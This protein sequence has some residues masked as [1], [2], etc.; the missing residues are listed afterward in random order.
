MVSDIRITAR[1]AAVKMRRTTRAPRPRAARRDAFCADT[2]ARS[3]RHVMPVFMLQRY[4]A[5][6]MFAFSSAA[7]PCAMPLPRACLL[8]K[9][10]LLLLRHMPRVMQREYQ[11]CSHVAVYD[12]RFRDQTL[13]RR[14]LPD[15]LR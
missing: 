5:C 3:V 14:R 7:M 15:T 10:L 9:R 1:V 13:R 8:L 4:D 12:E 11:P 6:A 2:M